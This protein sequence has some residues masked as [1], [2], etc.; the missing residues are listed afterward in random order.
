VRKHF[1]FWIIYHV[2]AASQ[3]RSRGRGVILGS[4]R[5]WAVLLVF[6]VLWMCLDP[7]VGSAQ[8]HIVPLAELRGELASAA[9]VR[10]ANLSDIERAL[11]LPA[12]RDALEKVHVNPDQVRDA[13]SKLSDEELSRLADRARGA[14]QDVQGGL[15]VGLL[16]LIGLVVV[17]IIV[18]ALVKK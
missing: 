16:A 10:A 8:D 12:A 17:I 7:R 2:N 18:V 15:I 9:T 3:H 1:P 5:Q 6:T 11:A 13:V 14:Q 4:Q